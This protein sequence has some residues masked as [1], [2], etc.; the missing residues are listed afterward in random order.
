MEALLGAG[1]VSYTV[2]HK[3]FKVVASRPVYSE[4]D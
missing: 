3:T 1:K 4:P 2:D